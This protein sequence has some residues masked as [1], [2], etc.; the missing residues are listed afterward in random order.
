MAYNDD[1]VLARLSSLNESHD[2]IATAAQWIMFHR[3]HAE[4][5]VQLWLQRL[6]DSSSTKRLSLIY[7]A[8]E[9]AQ[10]SKI[11][12]KDD[13]I[14]AFAP[15]IAEAAS[16]A[17]KGAPAELQAKLKRVID[18]WR[19]RSIFEAPIQAAI[20]ARI[21]ELDKARGMA[22]PGFSGSAFASGGA[23]ASAGAAIPSEFAPL[24]SAHQSVTKL[25][26]PLKATVASASQ[27]Y[28]KQTDPSTPVPSAPVYAARL[29]GLLKTLANAEN[30]VAECVKARE[31]LV[32]GLETLLNANRAALEQEKSD[33]AQLVSR[34]AEI[35]EKKQQV[36]IGIMRALGPADSNGNPGDA[37]SLIAPAEPDRP[38]M[39]AL[40]PPAFDP[41]DAPTPEALT[42]E[43]EP[44]VAP[45]P[46]T[47]EETAS[48]QS[49][50]ISI[51]GSNKRRRID[52]EEFPDLGGDD[53][54][55]A[56]VAQMLKEESQS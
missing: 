52:T 6:K 30:A 12:H 28:E 33:H 23:A 3:R 24:V 32:S 45:A 55:D 29:N 48:Y 2:S 49:L 9:V 22:K 4:R 16:V 5:T 31:G 10:Q 21:G 38:E 42:P 51:N 14:I 44:A 50:P 1:S 41:F 18:V 54:I 11:R 19:D 46:A 36:E 25:S 13:F 8:N 7:L 15:V 43:G 34:K 40:T 53:G 39:E 37:E 27:E 56:D 20:D 35:E 17:Y 47:E 26:P